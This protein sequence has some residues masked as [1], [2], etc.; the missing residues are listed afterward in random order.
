MSLSPLPMQDVTPWTLYEQL[1][2]WYQ[3]QDSFC[4]FQ[5][6]CNGKGLYTHICHR[7]VLAPPPGEEAHSSSKGDMGGGA[8]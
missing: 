8:C 7:A 4:G 1:H 3:Q 6:S 5:T 2:S